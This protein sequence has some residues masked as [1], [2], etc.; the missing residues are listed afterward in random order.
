LV[1]LRSTKKLNKNA[2]IVSVVFGQNVVTVIL[3]IGKKLNKKYKTAKPRWTHVPLAGS[4]II[5]LL[6]GSLVGLCRAS[7]GLISTRVT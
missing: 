3:K 7:I 2:A 5:R 4:T 6:L 1:E